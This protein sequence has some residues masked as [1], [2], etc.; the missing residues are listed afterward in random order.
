MPPKPEFEG[1]SEYLKVRGQTVSKSFD[2]DLDVVDEESLWSY[3]LPK[4]VNETVE[5]YRV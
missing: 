2:I 1:E 3:Q 4:V 5:G